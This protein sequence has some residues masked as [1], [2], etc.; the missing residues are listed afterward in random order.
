MAD[1]TKLKLHI[2]VAWWVRVWIWALIHVAVLSGSTPD[3]DKVG[4]MLARG[5]RVR[6]VD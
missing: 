1:A 6:V 4:R 5:M 2:T 3:W